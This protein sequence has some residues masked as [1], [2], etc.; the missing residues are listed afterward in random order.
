[1]R[2]TIA[3]VSCGILAS[4][5]LAGCSTFEPFTTDKADAFGAKPLIHSESFQKI[6]LALLLNPKAEKTIDEAASLGDQQK[7]IAAAY[8]AFHKNNPTSANRRVRNSL[9]ERILSA[10]N[11]RCGEYKNLLKTLDSRAN[12]FLG[13]LTTAIAGAGAIVSGG[14]A[15][16]SGTASII[17]GT[18]A[19]F[20][21]SYFQNQTIQ[22]LTNGFDT[23]RERLY[24]EIRDRRKAETDEY[25]I[26]EAIKDAVTYH[27]FCSLNAGLEEAGLAIERQKN[28][29]ITQFESISGRLDVMRAQRNFVNAEVEVAEKE[30]A[31]D[32]LKKANKPTAAAEAELKSVKAF[33]DRQLLTIKAYRKMLTDISGANDVADK[34]AGSNDG[35]SK[36]AKPAA[37]PVPKVQKD[38]N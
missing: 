22:V 31:I 24:Q 11:Q 3:R 5:A 23:K 2:N 17:S 20:N 16:L 27:S 29:G 13:T 37:A 12:F 25:T 26:E 15:V 38:N 14:S 4:A 8:E 21:N 1:M 34:K 28:P 9:Q 18:R 33:R 10:S 36:P 6:D 19:E 7:Q 30:Q 35:A 32:E